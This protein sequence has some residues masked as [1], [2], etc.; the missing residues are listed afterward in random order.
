MNCRSRWLGVVVNW[1][2][3]PAI[4]CSNCSI[5]ST[6][7]VFFFSHLTRAVS[8]DSG[9]NVKAAKRACRLVSLDLTEL[10]GGPVPAT[11]G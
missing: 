7:S 11:W 5:S 6:N 3:I 1:L 4:S 10:S 8:S 2:L 9:C